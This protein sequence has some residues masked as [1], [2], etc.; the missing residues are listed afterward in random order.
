[1]KE[2]IIREVIKMIRVFIPEN[3]GREKTSARGFWRNEA[4][5]IY[6]D[7]LKINAYNK[8]IETRTNWIEFKRFLEGIQLEHNQEAVFYTSND[9]GYIFYNGLKIEVL[10]HRIFKEVARGNLKV[11]IKDALRDFS[12]CTIYIEAGRYYIE[13]FYK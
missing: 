2:A 13:I 11:A 6:Y 9:L 7:Y 10:R 5:Q 1:L 3:K 8:N 12:G 4:G